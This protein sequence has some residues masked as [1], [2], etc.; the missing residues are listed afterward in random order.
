MD[1]N[2]AHFIRPKS[3]LNMTG[4]KKLFLRHFCQS[5]GKTEVTVLTCHSLFT[6]NIFF[7]IRHIAKLFIVDLFIIYSMNIIEDF[8]F[9]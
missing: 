7:F 3:D 8:D 2:L 6:V 4:E 5:E 1:F 9:F